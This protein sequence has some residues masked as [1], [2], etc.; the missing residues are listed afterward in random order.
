MKIK[1]LYE[2]R[3]DETWCRTKETVNH[4]QWFFRNRLGNSC[5]Q[6]KKRDE[7]LSSTLISKSNYF[8]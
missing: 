1:S 6:K 2:G 4:I 5:F 3:N 8:L 7:A